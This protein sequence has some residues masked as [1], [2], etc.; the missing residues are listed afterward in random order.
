[1]VREQRQLNKERKE[2]WAAHLASAIE[3]R[4]FHAVAQPDG[5]VTICRP[6]ERDIHAQELKQHRKKDSYSNR[7]K[8]CL[9][10]HQKSS[11]PF[12][13]EREEWRRPHAQLISSWPQRAPHG[14][15]LCVTTEG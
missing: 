2:L 15:Q 13:G 11:Q 7:L 6:L 4:P 10:L 8:S 9:C 14:L 3:K 12:H 5:T 1:M